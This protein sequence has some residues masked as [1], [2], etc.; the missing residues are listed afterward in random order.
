M[1]PIQ[2]SPTKRWN[3]LEKM[4]TM[5]CSAINDPLDVPSFRCALLPPC[6]WA[7]ARTEW[8]LLFRPSSIAFKRALTFTSVHSLGICLPCP[9]PSPNPS[10]IFARARVQTHCSSTRC[11]R[12]EASTLALLAATATL[13]HQ[14]F[15]KTHQLAAS[16]ESIRLDWQPI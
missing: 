16:K 11:K 10:L 9:F 8:K 7:R 3:A 12:T 2:P 6:Q 15:R 4:H 13:E 5:Q 1:Y 14:T